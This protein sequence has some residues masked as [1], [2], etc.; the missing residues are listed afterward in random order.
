MDIKQYL[1][2]VNDAPE[3][4]GLI[5]QAREWIAEGWGHKGD[6]TP[7]EIAAAL[8]NEADTQ[9]ECVKNGESDPDFPKLLRRIAYRILLHAGHETELTGWIDQNL[10][11]ANGLYEEAE[12]DCEDSDYEDI[13][14]LE[15]SVYNEGVIRTLEDLKQ[16][17]GYGE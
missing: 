9:D 14:A 5:D 2:R 3:T 15:Q 6:P 13:D 8:F 17:I 11:E 4:K 7:A 1:Q 12:K 16:L 10:S